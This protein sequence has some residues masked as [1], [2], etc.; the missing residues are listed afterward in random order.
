V[1]PATAGTSAGGSTSQPR[2]QPVMPKYLEKLLTTTASGASSAA[3][4]A[5]SP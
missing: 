4:V 5:G 2:R 1:D 3:L